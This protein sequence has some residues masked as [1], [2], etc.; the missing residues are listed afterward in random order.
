MR[1]R[2]QVYIPCGKLYNKTFTRVWFDEQSAIVIS[3]SVVPLISR[4][5]KYGISVV[6]PSN[7][8]DCLN[9]FVN[10]LYVFFNPDTNSLFCEFC[11]KFGIV[12]AATTPIMP[13]VNNTST[14]VNPFFVKLALLSFLYFC[15]PNFFN[16]S[17]P[18]PVF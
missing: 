15:K 8:S 9:P 11:T 5:V 3:L 16:G 12:I 1:Y 18:S 6:F 4:S 13:R 17:V 14:R 7:T 2:F 10:V